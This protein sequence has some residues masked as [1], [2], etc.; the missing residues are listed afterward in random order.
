MSSSIT[1]CGN[2]ATLLSTRRM[3]L[4]RAG[5]DIKT[6]LGPSELD[7][8]AAK[9]LMLCYSLTESE[10]LEA[11]HA[12]RFRFPEARILALGGDVREQV[13]QLCDTLSA[14]ETPHSLIERTRQLA[15][16]QSGAASLTIE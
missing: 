6:V 7:A 1:I 13:G 8:G 4:E 11:I 3:L 5:F 2:D 12:V 14:F 15:R 16:E 10:Q 9:L